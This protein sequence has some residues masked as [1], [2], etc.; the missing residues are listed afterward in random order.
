MAIKV[1]MVD[2]HH[3]FRDGV[4]SLID[5]EDDMEVIGSAGSVEDYKT[6]ILNYKPDVILMDLTI[7]SEYGVDAINWLREQGNETKVI[8]LSMHKEGSHVQKVLDCG[9]NGYILK[10]SGTAEMISG[11]RA[12]HNGE[13]FYSQDIMSSIVNQLTRSKEPKWALGGKKLSQ[14]EIEVLKLIAL[15]NSNQEI[16]DKL[17]I[18][19]RTVDTH[20]R[21]IMDKLDA[22]NTVSLVKYAIKN[23]IIEI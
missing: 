6:D 18:S 21:N 13:K 3:I 1:Y 2:D 11:I 10:D 7:G 23:H 8:V 15:E 14:R 20:R 17:F 22:K 5:F 4:T 19:I 12:V 9:A 16:A